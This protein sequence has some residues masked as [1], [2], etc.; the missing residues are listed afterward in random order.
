[1][2]KPRTQNG[3][4]L[5]TVDEFKAMLGKRGGK[6]RGQHKAGEM[7]GTER[8][9]ANLL[10]TRKAAGEVLW[11]EFEAMK[12]KLAPGLTFTPDFAVWISSAGVAQPAYMEFIDVKG[13]GP[14]QDD[15][16]VKIK[17]AARLFP[18]FH[19]YQEQK[20][21]KKDGGGFRRRYF[22]PGVA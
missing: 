10:A 2:S 20:L 4:T 1:M 13:S 14:I 15:A 11:Y 7:N 3:V 17:M 16:L 5:T 8:A 19:F 18:M 9:Y 12:L 22:S 21:K 6:A